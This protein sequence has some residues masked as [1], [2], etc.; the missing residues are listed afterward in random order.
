MTIFFSHITFVKTVFNSKY[1]V[2][3]MVLAR[4]IARNLVAVTLR[5]QYELCKICLEVGVLFRHK[6]PEKS[7]RTSP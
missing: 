7:N 3:H 1:H 4:D 6:F 5:L 2:N